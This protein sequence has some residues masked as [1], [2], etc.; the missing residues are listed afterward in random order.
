MTFTPKLPYT[1]PQSLQL[2][3][4][5][6]GPL[7]KARTHERKAEGLRQERKTADE[8]LEKAEAQ[9]RRKGAAP[10]EDEGPQPHLEFLERWKAL[11]FTVTPIEARARHEWSNR[12][13]KEPREF[14]VIGHLIASLPRPRM[15]ALFKDPRIAE[16]NVLFGHRDLKGVIDDN[17]LLQDLGIAFGTFVSAK[18][19]LKF[20][21]GIQTYKSA[22][23]LA[24][25]LTVVRAAADPKA[26]KKKNFVTDRE[27]LDL[28]GGILREVTTHII[29]EMQGAHD[30]FFA[31][32]D[33]K[34]VGEQFRIDRA[35]KSGRPV[36]TADAPKGRPT[37]AAPAKAARPGGADRPKAGA[38]KG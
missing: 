15:D 12:F 1:V 8:A 11:E 5:D 7:V 2:K 18:R 3:K 4:A 20:Q 32:G 14:E 24:L 23:A 25:Y 17:E 26:R 37:P 16:L 33:R 21:L 28:A 19:D 27:V 9:P 13:G 6:P 29:E 38:L 31:V 34:V 30:S 10:A 22:Q 35:K 36:P